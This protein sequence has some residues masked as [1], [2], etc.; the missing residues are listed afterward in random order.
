MVSTEVK[1][2]STGCYLPSQAGGNWAGSVG[3]SDNHFLSE[4]I[5]ATYASAGQQAFMENWATPTRSRDVLLLSTDDADQ[6]SSAYGK[7]AAHRIDAGR[8]VLRRR[9]A[10]HRRR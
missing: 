2:G 7:E 3:V 9:L 5:F 10:G 1:A 6:V 8:Q 4:W